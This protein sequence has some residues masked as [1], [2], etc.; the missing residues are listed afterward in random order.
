MGK[1]IVVDVKECMACRTCEIAC[2]LAHSESKT[3]DEAMKKQEARINVEGNIELWA[4]ILCRH[5]EDAPCVKICPTGAIN[6]QD[7]NGPVLIE[8]DLCIGC[9]F[10][11]VVC[12]FG[13]IGPSDEGRTVIK[14]DLCLERLEIGQ[15]PACVASCPMCALRLVEAEEY[16]RQKRAEAAA[17]LAGAVQKGNTKEE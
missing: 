6:R 14:C 16:V 13:V 4:P 17:E 9:K 7:P 5:C 15:E 10:C 2:A 11:L 8:Q 12:P 1:I 3:L